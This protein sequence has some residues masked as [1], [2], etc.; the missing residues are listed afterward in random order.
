L[1]VHNLDE[2]ECPKTPL[3]LLISPPSTCNLV[4][5]SDTASSWFDV[6]G[7]VT[8]AWSLQVGYGLEAGCLKI[9][10]AAS[11]TAREIYREI[12]RIGFSLS[13]DIIYFEA[14]LSVSFALHHLYLPAC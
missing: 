7:P 2:A 6:G 10:T 14:E 1:P 9:P 12:C 4:T 8:D 5:S 13:R 3:T 11:V